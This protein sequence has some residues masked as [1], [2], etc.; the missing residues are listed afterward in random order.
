M[1]LWSRWNV[2]HVLRRRNKKYL[3]T[4]V[5]I[6]GVARFKHWIKSI[7][8]D[9]PS[10]YRHGVGP[11][12]T[13]CVWWSG[14]TLYT[15]CTSSYVF[16]PPLPPLFWTLTMT[17]FHTSTPRRPVCLTT[18]MLRLEGKYHTLAELGGGFGGGGGWPPLVKIFDR[19][20][21]L[22]CRF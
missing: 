11:V 4:Y 16:C 2:A 3:F 8:R 9:M 12:M 14:A 17:A 10:V 1:Y 21:N 6:L 18:D 5:N 22:F 13:E 7:W 20:G 15:C 19:K